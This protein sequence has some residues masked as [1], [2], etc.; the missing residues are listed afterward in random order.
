[1][2]VEIIHDTLAKRVY[3]LIDSEDRMWLKIEQFIHN[4]YQYFLDSGALIANQ[5]LNYIRPYLDQ[6]HISKEEREFIYLSQK[7]AE[8]N[9][10]K[11][12]LV[13]LLTVGA[14][15][16][17]ANLFLRFSAKEKMLMQAQRQICVSNLAANAIQSSSYDQT[18]AFQLAKI[19]AEYDP[20]NH[21]AK[22][23]ESSILFRSGEYPFYHSVIKGHEFPIVDLAIGSQH[24]L[25]LSA[26]E[27]GKVFIHSMEGDAILAF[28]AHRGKIY[29]VDFVSYQKEKHL[30]TASH[31][32]F[33]TLWNLQ[34]DSIQAFPHNSPINDVS[35]SK[36]KRFIITVGHDGYAK[37]WD[38]SANLLSENHLH[39][40]KITSIDLMDDQEHLISSDIMGNIKITHLG[41]GERK[42]DFKNEGNAVM[43]MDFN[44]KSKLLAVGF[45][46]GTLKLFQLSYRKGKFSEELKIFFKAHTKAIDDLVLDHSGERPLI[47]TSSEDNSA[48][49][50]DERGNKLKTL[51]GH[52]EALHAIDISIS[53]DR[54]EW[55]AV[56]GGKGKVLKQ[57]F[58]NPY[59]AASFKDSSQL[60]KVEFNNRNYSLTA[61]KNNTLILRN[62]AYQEI[63]RIKTKDLISDFAFSTKGDRIFSLNDKLQL[64]V[65]NLEGK[66]LQEF[67]LDGFAPSYSGAKM[68]FSQDGK[69]FL[70]SLGKHILLYKEDGTFVKSL[71]GH[72]QDITQASFSPDGAYI[73]SAS[74]DSSLKLW[75]LKD[76]SHSSYQEHASAVTSFAFF[77]DSKQFVSG[78]SDRSIRLW[79]IG[80]KKSLK[81]FV[82]HTEG[83]SKLDVSADGER[84]LS[85][86]QDHTVRLWDKDGGQQ[87]SFI[88]HK[89][90]IIGASFSQ[91]GK[92]IG[93]T[94][95]DHQVKIWKL[96]SIEEL[97][98]SIHKMPE[99][100]KAL[101]LAS[102]CE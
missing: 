35:M 40:H 30:L 20:N 80:K 51:L 92:Y 74:E 24:K 8:K 63:A 70:I 47:L 78:S 49:L 22:S 28:Q 36:D 90:P 31:E 64:S 14:F 16:F 9:S 32:G 25:L 6:V 91:D 72:S 1:M 44:G 42:L 53:P 39:E 67:P 55:L 102:A 29:D 18:L 97:L 75:D 19:A 98:G 38:L 56:T 65:W 62:A 89:Q 79:S 52:T 95:A 58:L 94:D 66:L 37:K 85:A 33:A 23:I 45:K 4:R 13:I 15:I 59:E 34:G 82:G 86:S 88:S 12:K 5:D 73:L 46:D 99:E 17:A 76:F 84:I 93:S 83:I 54:K 100:E 71:E 96:D 50:W 68:D 77:P 48:I 81:H 2:K 11:R 43:N 87:L 61:L 57:W 21:S 26:D 7:K 41:T 60:A 101:M 10:F 27:S 69:N 3:N